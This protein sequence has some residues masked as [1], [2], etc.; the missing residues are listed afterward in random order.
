VY[1]LSPFTPPAF[2][3]VEI[4]MLSLGD[5]DAIL[6]TEWS[7]NHVFRVLIDGGTADDAK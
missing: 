1:N 5:A 7:G 2:Y 4:D 3:G 6:V